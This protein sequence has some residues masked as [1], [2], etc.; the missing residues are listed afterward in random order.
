MNSLISEIENNIKLSV[1]RLISD[2]YGIDEKELIEL[3]SSRV[4]KKPKAKTIEIPKPKANCQC[5]NAT[6]RENSFYVD[7][8]GAKDKLVE[9]VVG[10]RSPLPSSTRFTSPPPSST[11]FTSPPPITTL[12]PRPTRFTRPPTRFTRIHPITTC[13]PY[14]KS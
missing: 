8:G 5:P 13:P 3:L 11:R 6:Y 7:H 1:A 9:E 2:E 14:P 4:S 12:P 10:T